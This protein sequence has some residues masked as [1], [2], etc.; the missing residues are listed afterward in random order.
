MPDGEATRNRRAN[1]DVEQPVTIGPY[2]IE[3][4]REMA[5]G[6]F[7]ALATDATGKT[8]RLWVGAPGRTTTATGDGPDALVAALSRVY[9]SSLPR[10][11]TA[12][13]IDDRAVVVLQ[14]YQ[15]RTLAD[16]LAEAAPAATTGTAGTARCAACAGDRPRRRRA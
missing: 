7:D 13:V 14:P 12:S 1:R 4:R 16:A 9:H 11:L 3:S 6:G 8:V 10:P 2:S 5:G 15:G